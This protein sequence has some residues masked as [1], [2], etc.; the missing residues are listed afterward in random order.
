MSNLKNKMLDNRYILVK[1]IGSGSFSTVWLAFDIDNIQYYA[2]KIQNTDDYADACH[3]ISVYENIREINSSYLMNIHNTF[4]Y[5]NENE[6]D[7]YD[8]DNDNDN[9]HVCMVMDLMECSTHNLIKTK[10]YKH[11]LPFDI[12]MIITKQILL[13][14]VELHKKNIIHKD[15]KPENILI[16]GSADLHK[17]IKDTL[18]AEKIVEKFTKTKKGKK[19]IDKNNI[20]KA[21]CSVNNQN[22]DS[23]SES[24]SDETE[25]SNDINTL[26][27]DTHSNEQSDD[28]VFMCQINK[29]ITVKLADMGH[30]I[31]PDI[32]F[33]YQIQSNYYLAPE[34]IMKLQFNNSVD[35]WALGCTIYELLTGQILF[36]SES[37]N[38]NTY[39]HHLYIMAEKLGMFPSKYVNDCTLKDI[40]FNKRCTC[41]KGYRGIKFQRPLWRDLQ[42]ICRDR[43]LSLD[44]ERLFI[45]FMMG[46]FKYDINMRTTSEQALNHEIFNFF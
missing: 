14:I 23:E 26:Q 9:P 13:G 43:S 5:T 18:N 17:C 41:I 42:N 19:Q 7:E 34:L 16:C 25:S 37:Y 32:D 30:C 40:F 8:N 12:V 24:A 29:N 4:E 15:I 44:D 31:L 3:E 28:D 38:G 35:M 10:Q 46:L 21:I 39:R 2:L 27:L 22:I 33:P 36:E 45:D 11:G 1:E 20:F 6:E